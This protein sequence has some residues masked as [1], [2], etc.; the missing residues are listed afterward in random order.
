MVEKSLK[1]QPMVTLASFAR[2]WF[3]A[4]SSLEKVMGLLNNVIRTAVISVLGAKLAKGRSP[5]VAALLMLLVSKAMSTAPGRKGQHGSRGG[6][7]SLIESSARA[8]WRISSS[9]GSGPAE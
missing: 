6:L 7:G 1:E 8:A 3:R 9:R 4:R 5:I 2:H